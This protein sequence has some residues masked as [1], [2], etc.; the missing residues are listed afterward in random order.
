MRSQNGDRERERLLSP[1]Y[2]PAVQ[3]T[4]LERAASDDSTRKPYPPE[5]EAHGS[6]DGFQLDDSERKTARQRLVTTI[7][8]NLSAIME[9]TDEQLLPAVY[10]FVGESFQVRISMQWQCGI[11]QI[12]F[13]WVTGCFSGGC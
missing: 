4:D 6:D 8:I 12:Q 3:E 2:I 10:R 9:R 11:V 7:L 13:S 1:S 5:P